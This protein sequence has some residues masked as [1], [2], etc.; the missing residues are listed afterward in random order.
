MNKTIVIFIIIVVLIGGGAFYGGM[1]YG[2]SQGRGS[3]QQGF[4]NLTPAQ[5]QQF[6]QQSGGNRTGRN[7]A[8]GSFIS[9]QVIAKDDK[10]VTVQSA[11]G[12]GSKIVFFSAS[13]QIMKTAS[14]TASD[15]L[16][17]DN[18][19]INGQANQ[20]GSITAQSIQIRPAI[21]NQPTGQQ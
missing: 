13:T 19:T 1:V 10:S 7:N 12:S 6:S 17:G 16:V 11:D 2:K 9:G 8:N 5:R 20:D 18:L 15:L 21:P 4:Q 3:S 14:S